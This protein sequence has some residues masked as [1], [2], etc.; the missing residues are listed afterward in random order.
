MEKV[1]RANKHLSSLNRSLERFIK[2]DPYAIRVEQF[3]S[4]IFLQPISRYVSKGVARDFLS[5]YTIS[6]RAKPIR[7]APTLRWGG[8]VGDIVH[9]LASALDNAVWELAQLNEPDWRRLYTAASNTQRRLYDRRWLTL[10][11]PYTKNANEWKKNIDRYLFFLDRSLDTIFEQ[12]QP[13]YTGQRSGNDPEF[14]PLWIL[15]ELWNR[16]KHR[17]VNLTTASVGFQSISPR[18]PG[19]FPG[20]PELPAG[21]IKAF[22]L[23]PIEGE[24]EVAVVRLQLPK[25]SR[26]VRR[27]ICKWTLS[28]PWQYCSVK[29][30]Q[31]QE[32]M[33]SM[34][35]KAPGTLSRPSSGSSPDGRV[36]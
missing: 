19:L 22:P 23:R 25:K 27:S 2:S 36:K 16:D 4:D 11:F 18:M 28:C 26:S 24:T 33:C 6:V 10:G 29:L 9:N 32:A 7:A 14:E 17:T 35:C 30:R 1:R 13:F 34:F 21:T 12:S 20:D 3:K 31:R 8:V 5:T 15:H